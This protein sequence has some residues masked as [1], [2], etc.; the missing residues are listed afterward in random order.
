MP[1]QCAHWLAMTDKIGSL[2]RRGGEDTAPTDGDETPNGS[3]FP[4]P[5][6]KDGLPRAAS[7]PRNDG[8]KNGSPVQYRPGR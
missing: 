1:R 8:M 6:E 3:T 2:S 4:V 7:G 5:K